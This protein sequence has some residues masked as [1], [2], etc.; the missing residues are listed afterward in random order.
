MKRFLLTLAGCAALSAFTFAAAPAEDSE[1]GFVP[2]FD[3]KTFNG[4]K[5]A[6]ENTNSWTVKDGAFVAHGNRCHIFYVGDTKPFKD[7]ELKVDVMTQPHSNGGI[8]FHTRYQEEGWPKGGFECQV[9]NTHADWKKTGSLYDVV[10]IAQNLA[11][12]NKWWTQEIIVKDKTVTVIIDGKKIFEYNEPPG[13]QPGKPFARKLGEG[14]FALQ[15]HDPNS[16]IHYKNIR[17]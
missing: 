13:V 8:Y 10:N 15:G 3:G 2:I 6:T 5:T 1:E 16:T 12:D 7:F 17:V 11:T 9:N 14:T 4:W